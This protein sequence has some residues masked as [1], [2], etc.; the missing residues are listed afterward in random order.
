MLC[1]CFLPLK[2]RSVNCTGGVCHIIIMVKPCQHTKSIPRIENFKKNPEQ[3][4]TLVVSLFL[5]KK[6]S[7]QQ[8]QKTPNP[9][10][11]NKK[12]LCKCIC[13]LGAAL[14]LLANCQS[15]LQNSEV[16]VTQFKSHAKHSFLPLG[17]SSREWRLSPSPDYHPSVAAESISCLFSG[18]RPS[19][20][21][22]PSPMSE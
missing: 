17:S 21:T 7:N 14:R 15:N 10:N 8:Q 6:K 13:K 12:H 18:P 22:V 3:C 9:R 11:H 4:Y 1:W 5:F 19:G 20:A 16:W 2:T